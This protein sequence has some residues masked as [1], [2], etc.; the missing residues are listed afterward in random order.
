MNKLCKKCN[1]NKSFNSFYKNKSMK[2]GL[3]HYCKSCQNKANQDSN[4]NN[5]DKRKETLTKW[6]NNNRPKLRQQDKDRYDKNNIKENKKIWQRNNPVRRRAI[7]KRHYDKNIKNN[8]LKALPTR[9]CIRLNTALKKNKKSGSVVRDLGCTIPELKIYLESRF[10][11]GMTWD[12]YGKGHGKWQIDHILPLASFDLTNRNELIKACHYT[13]LQPLWG[14]DNNHKN[15][16][17]PNV[18]RARNKVKAG[19]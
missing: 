11:P 5:K 10:Q 16:L 1:I 14:I 18:T 15:D 12:N 7:K 19:L 2:D 4:F 9:L 6:R 13:N 17:L 3:G 8:P